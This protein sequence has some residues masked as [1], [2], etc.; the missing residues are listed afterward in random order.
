MSKSA[1]R[2]AIIA[3]VL[4]IISVGVFGILVY[5][6]STK[7]VQL[8]EHIAVLGVHRSQQNTFFGLRKTAEETDTERAALQSLFF[9]KGSDSVDFLNTVEGLGPQIGATIET[10][11]ISEKTDKDTGY[12]WLVIDFEV[13]GDEAAVEEGIQLMEYL[14]YAVRLT[15]IV[16][17]E[18]SSTLSV[19]NVTL[20]VR[21]LDYDA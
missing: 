2:T 7:E 10:I 3:V 17:E 8:Q 15:S 20:Q 6:V 13:T 11:D 5:Q 4:L 9:L 19:A 16:L 18:R 12:K 14:P 21:L 1:I